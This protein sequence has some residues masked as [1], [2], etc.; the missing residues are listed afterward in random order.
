MEMDLLV[1]NHTYYTYI[2]TYIYIYIYI[3]LY[4]TYIYIYKYIQIYQEMSQSDYPILGVRIASAR[5]R[6]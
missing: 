5:K 1:D 3:Y 4:F 6:F 2:Y